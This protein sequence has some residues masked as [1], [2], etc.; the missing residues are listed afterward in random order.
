[1]P[2]PLISV[3]PREMFSGRCMIA[4]L[5]QTLIILTT[6]SLVP[7]V[8][9]E[10]PSLLGRGVWISTE[11]PCFP[12]S[13]NR[14]KAVAGMVTFRST[15]PA[16]RRLCSRRQFRIVSDK[17]PC[18][19]LSQV[20]IVSC[21]IL[22]LFSTETGIRNQS[23]HFSQSSIVHSP[24][25]LEYQP[26]APKRLRCSMQIDAGRKWRI[27]VT[28]VHLVSRIDASERLFRCVDRIQTMGL[29]G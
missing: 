27:Q 22:G 1:M 29:L 15:R 11:R 9:R 23:N 3:Q 5:C 17:S 20:E 18:S 4:A 10:S 19:S 26:Q 6:F 16:P 28:F 21:G 12:S 8:A 13:A 24:G 7:D 14:L 25:P 2:R